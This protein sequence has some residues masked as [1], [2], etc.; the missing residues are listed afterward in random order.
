MKAGCAYDLSRDRQPSEAMASRRGQID[1]AHRGEADAD[2]CP[3]PPRG[4]DKSGPYGTL[5]KNHTH[6]HEGA[7]SFRVARMRENTS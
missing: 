2:V 3:T 7:I 1:R 6:T 4:R 5:C